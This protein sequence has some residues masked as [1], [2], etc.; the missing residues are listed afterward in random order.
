MPQRGLLGIAALSLAFTACGKSEKSA[1]VDTLASTTD[2]G[3]QTQQTRSRP[4]TMPFI[5]TSTAFAPNGSIPSKYTCEGADMSPP[6][7]WFGA[8]SD[9]KT[10]ALIVDDPD[11]PDPA[12]PQRVYVHWVVY[13]IPANITKL[14]ENAAKAGM[15]SGAIQGIN[16]WKKETY[17]GPCPPIGRHRYFFKLYA[18]DTVLPQLFNPTKSQLEKAME[19][20]LVGNAELV[21]TYQKSKS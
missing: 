12:R 11:A 20:H 13:N 4:K 5:L 21:G 18:L 7:E 6:L 9:A 2:S 8:P 10:I 14:P 1:A 19:E 17:G 16:D 15:P 3:P